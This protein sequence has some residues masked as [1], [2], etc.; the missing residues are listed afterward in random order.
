[1][2][3]QGSRRPED[4]SIA[5]NLIVRG[6]EQAIEFYQN[7]LGAEVLY[8]GAMPNGVTL[9]AQLRIAGSYVF[10]S[11]DVMSR[12]DMATGSPQKLGG[13][14]TIM[15]LFVDDVDA[16]F[17]RA[18]AAGGKPLGPV[19]DAFYGDRVGMFTD[20]FGHMWSL[21]TTKEVLTPQQLYDRM[22]EHF[23]QLQS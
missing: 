20:P 16:A 3:I 8:R 6:V 5:P 10:L 15:D 4:R 22:L 11:D 18:V 14:T 23:S 7:A 13:V 2:S 9:H 1:M 12:P 17:D 19:E 21:A